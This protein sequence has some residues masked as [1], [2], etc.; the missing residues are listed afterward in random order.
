MECRFRTNPRRLGYAVLIVA[1]VW[2][3]WHALVKINPDEATHIRSFLTFIVVVVPFVMLI[4]FGS[5][6]II[7]NDITSPPWPR[8][9]PLK[10]SPRDYLAAAPIYIGLTAWLWLHWRKLRIRQ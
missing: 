3:L 5:A 8:A 9:L 4:Y 7:Y 1:T 2:I 10:L 6:I